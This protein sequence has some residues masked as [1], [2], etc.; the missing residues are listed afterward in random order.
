MMP[1]LATALFVKLLVSPILIGLASLAGKRWGTGVSGLLGGL[2]LVGAPVV[3]VLWFGDA[4]TG[5]QAAA[6]APVGVWATMA[7]LLA[8]GWISHQRHW[9]RVLAASWC[10]YLAIAAL[11]HFSG[12][13]RSPVMAWGV[14][15]VLL[16]AAARGLPA[17]TMAPRSAHLPR[18]ELIA[19][20]V[21]ALLLVLGLTTAASHIG[22]GFTGV[23]AGAPVAATVIPAF[24]LALAGRDALL[25]ALRGFL[26]GLVGFA[27]F[28]LTLSAALPPYG[29][30]AWPLAAVAAVAAG[31][32]AVQVVRH[33]ARD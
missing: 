26:T 8:F 29:G 7:Y 9:A 25:R 10:V 5:T 3:L 33:A 20:M 18:Q 15:P 4:A 2:P 1:V 32:L 11:L 30:W 27:S 28:F 13:D 14:L 23:L 21:A 19:R 22:A 24:T 16:L 17:P 31:A 12:L 6:T